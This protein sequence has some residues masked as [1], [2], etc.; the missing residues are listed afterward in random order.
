MTILEVEIKG[1]RGLA[2]PPGL[3]GLNGRD[4]IG[5]ESVVKLQEKIDLATLDA[6]PYFVYCLPSK[7]FAAQP[8]MGVSRP[9]PA[10]TDIEKHGILV[11]PDS[12]F[13][14]GNNKKD[15]PLIIFVHGS[16]MS[17][18]TG[19]SGN[20]LL[21][22]DWYS[23]ISKVEEKQCLMYMP[24]CSWSFSNSLDVR[25]SHAPA[26]GV[27]IMAAHKPTVQRTIPLHSDIRML[28][29]N[30]KSILSNFDVDSNAVF[31]MGSSRG[32]MLL[33]HTTDE[34]QDLISGSIM[35]GGVVDKFYD[36]LPPNTNI[37][38]FVGENDPFFTLDTKVSSDLFGVFDSLK[39][40][41]SVN[42][43]EI[44]NLDFN[45]MDTVL[46][47]E[48]NP[49]IL[50]RDNNGDPRV[51]VGVDIETSDNTT[52]SLWVEKEGAHSFYGYNDLLWFD[53]MF[54]WMM[55]YK[56][57]PTS[58]HEKIRKD[59]NIT[60]QLNKIYDTLIPLSERNVSEIDTSLSALPEYQVNIVSTTNKGDP[61]NNPRIYK[62]L[63]SQVQFMSGDATL[64]I[65]SY[66]SANKSGTLSVT[67]TDSSFNAYAENVLEFLDAPGWG[68]D[69]SVVLNDA[70]MKSIIDNNTQEA[71]FKVVNGVALT[72]IMFNTIM[73]PSGKS[74]DENLQVP[75]QNFF[76]DAIGLYGGYF[77]PTVGVKYM[78][79]FNDSGEL[80]SYSSMGVDVAYAGNM[81]NSIVVQQ[82]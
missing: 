51:V 78:L 2:G 72:D 35:I 64:K 23:G 59:T 36:I 70:E 60:A 47:S 41:T 1:P 32:A 69:Y 50:H 16:G 17:L 56:G 74:I 53:A 18:E 43:D 27:G 15:Y 54:D 11:V 4:G 26:I 31:A 68:T 49:V 48:G 66:D 28:R 3:D 73:N 62:N 29:A 24:L 58:D 21:I 30:I 39:K 45:T 65:L 55:K 44:D 40:L 63:N 9:D 10:M 38:F 8:T 79:M 7:T 6:L 33:A 19:I 37:L 80:S 13:E 42:D 76:P 75:D 20:D 61:L 71:G 34:L 77:Y 52:L 14:L 12:Y 67:Y 81:D 46:N 57:K 5:S 25:G 82:G 22:R